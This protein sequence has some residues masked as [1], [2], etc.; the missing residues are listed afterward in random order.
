[1]EARDAA[2]L[3][4]SAHRAHSWTFASNNGVAVLRA[5]AVHFP[6][7]DSST[8]R[9]RRSGA[10]G[11]GTLS[12]KVVMIGDSFQQIGMYLE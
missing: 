12:N 8:H 5:V 4:E 6:M 9:D 7:H 11:S 2:A 3:Q 1:M 10:F